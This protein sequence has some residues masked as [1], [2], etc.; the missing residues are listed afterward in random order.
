[1]TNLEGA[2]RS[3]DITL[4]TKVHI[5]LWFFQQSWTDVRVGS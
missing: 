2:L 4:L 1:M 3:R 5:K